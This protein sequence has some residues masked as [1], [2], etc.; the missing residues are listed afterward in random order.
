M[1]ITGRGS[2]LPVSSPDWGLAPMPTG[3][4]LLGHSRIRKCPRSPTF[5]MRSYCEYLYRIPVGE[6]HPMTIVWAVT[7]EEVSMD[8]IW[9]LRRV[10]YR[11]IDLFLTRI[12]VAYLI[13]G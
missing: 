10:R 7:T 12:Y 9:D 6:R 1:E 13:F 3:A 4:L 5:T 11:S 8:T 2:D